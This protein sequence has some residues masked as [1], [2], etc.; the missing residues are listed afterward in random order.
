[1]ALVNHISVSSP[2]PKPIARVRWP[3]WP[4]VCVLVAGCAVT[5]VLCVWLRGKALAAD[6]ARLHEEA[7]MQMEAMDTRIELFVEMLQRFQDQITRT[8]ELD[9]EHWDGLVRE[10]NLR[11]NYPGLAAV[12][13]WLYQP[14]EETVRWR[15][16]WQA[17]GLPPP[18]HNDL[19]REGRFLRS[20][21]SIVNDHPDPSFQTS[22]TSEA[23][24]PDETLWSKIVWTVGV[25]P[26]A[27]P[28]Q[29]VFDGRSRKPDRGFR[30]LLPL[31]Y[32]ERQP[33]ALIQERRAATP[34]DWPAAEFLFAQND[35]GN[36]RG[37]LYGEFALNQFVAS[38]LGDRPRAVG[39]VIYDTESNW[40]ENPQIVR[41]RI[42]GTPP[43]PEERPYLEERLETKHYSRRLLFDF[44]TTPAFDPHSLRR[45]P[46][47]AGLAGG[48]V[49]LLVAGLVFSQTRAR[50]RE[51]A[52]ADRLRAA[53]EQLATALRDRERISRE[54][55]DGALQ[56]IY[57]VGLGLAHCRNIFA[58]QPERVPVVISETMDSINSLVMNLRQF[59]LTL[60]ADVLEGGSLEPML[61]ALAR[62]VEVTTNASV[63][64][65]VDSALAAGL[66]A[67]QSLHLINLVREAVS[68]AIRH[69]E[70]TEVRVNL[71]A[72]AGGW[73]LL[74]RDNGCGFDTGQL[75][76][77]PGHGLRN[78]RARAT[79]LGASFV[80]E[81]QP[82]SGT[83]VRV[84]CGQAKS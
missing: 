83:L 19:S 55:H 63:A 48:C 46:L 59:L 41:T 44:Y 22:S 24:T 64:V 61:K 12:G 33:R 20:F 18:H 34:G 3:H 14:T 39:F 78:M 71:S 5:V 76:A 42:Y 37:S 43:A 56:S 31:F 2:V 57:A 17:I 51:T 49:T 28:G 40:R 21:H 84:E 65:Q 53:N 9:V 6:R 73:C 79:E 10:L 66:P 11:G 60:E 16:A 47:M 32:P 75:E 26:G 69:G 82:G 27:L 77:A 38:T 8:P 70:S 7:V 36:F 80:L 23:F 35:W 30:I 15:E 25:G 52:D 62:R 29:E 4:A 45:W 50:L 13:C 58:T 68:N 74:I 81:S 1:V 72:V 67:A 54:L